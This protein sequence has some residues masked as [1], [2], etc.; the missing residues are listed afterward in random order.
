MVVKT[1]ID[2]IVP[3]AVVGAGILL[4]GGFTGR[5]AIGKAGE[6]IGEQSTQALRGL[7]QGDHPDTIYRPD[8]WREDYD[9]AIDDYITSG[10]RDTPRI[11]GFAHAQPVPHPEKTQQLCI[12]DEYWDPVMQ[13][14]IVDYGFCREEQYALGEPSK[15]YG[16]GQ[17]LRAFFPG[18]GILD[19]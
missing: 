14:N 9:A 8:T 3:L 1:V 4:I 6:V 11:P 12:V 5:F 16:V 10:D 18:R 2:N 19:R 13:E 7:I 17:N 15:W